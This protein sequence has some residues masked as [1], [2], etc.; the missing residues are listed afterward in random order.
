MCQRKTRMLIVDKSGVQS[1]FAGRVVS[2]QHRN[3]TCSWTRVVCDNSFWQSDIRVC[4]YLS[5]FPR[6]HLIQKWTVILAQLVDECLCRYVVSSLQFFTSRSSLPTETRVGLGR[7]GWS[8]HSQI[9]PHKHACLCTFYYINRIRK[10]TLSDYAISFY[11]MKNK[12][13]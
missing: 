8:K 13:S 10:P 9:A 1:V 7:Q 3:G 2:Q 4:A 5:W 12:L 11:S 6:G